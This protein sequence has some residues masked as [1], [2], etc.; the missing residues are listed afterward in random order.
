[1]KDDKNRNSN[2][3]VPVPPLKLFVTYYYGRYDFSEQV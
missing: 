3:E 1:M 2:E